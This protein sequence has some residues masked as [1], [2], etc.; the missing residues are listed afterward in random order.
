[1]ELVK[2]GRNSSSPLSKIILRS[3]SMEKG[4]F[5]AQ[6]LQDHLELGISIITAAYERVVFAA[7]FVTV[8]FAA[9]EYVE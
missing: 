6:D 5:G 3:E 7:R 9:V 4:A 2:E 8:D 1:M